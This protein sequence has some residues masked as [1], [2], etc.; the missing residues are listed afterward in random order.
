MA[1]EGPQPNRRLSREE[2]ERKIAD[3]I[4]KRQ[5]GQPQDADDII[6]A[7]PEEDEESEA[8]EVSEEPEKEEEKKPELNRQDIEK[9]TGEQRVQQTPEEQLE[10][11]EVPKYIK[12]SPEAYKQPPGGP[13]VQP[14]KPGVVSEGGGKAVKQGASKAGQAVKSSVQAAGNAIKEAA[15]KAAQQVAKAVA[16]AASKAAAAALS[17]PYVLGAILIIILLI[18]LGIA[19]IALWPNRSLGTTPTQAADILEDHPLIKTVLAMSNSADFQKLLAENK[20]KLTS[21]INSFKNKLNSKYASNSRTGPT[22]AKLDEVL[23]LIAAYTTTDAVKAK[24]IRDKLLEAVKPWSVTL[25]PGGMIFPVSGFS[26]NNPGRGSDYYKYNS[27]RRTHRGIDRGIP[28]GTVF[29][30]P[31][32]SEIVHLDEKSCRDKIDAGWLNK[33]NGGFGNVIIGKV[34]A[35]NQWKGYYWE[36]H[37]LKQYSA[38]A[39]GIKEG[40]IVRQGQIIGLSGHNGKSSKPH[41]HF[42]IDK[43]EAGNQGFPV[44]IGRE[45]QTIDP[46]IPLGWPRK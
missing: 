17:N 40:S 41:I 14:K 18:G 21:E 10:A 6:A 23:K 25:S 27:L 30:A 36:I 39:Y 42:Q 32:D 2:Y 35:D 8:E 22:I 7:E 19:A 20:D 5:V 28:V 46:Y 4:S 16:Q 34:I 44:G 13:A 1:I 31:A 43:P 33:C 3:D 45:E 29:R 9:L 38:G 12:E 11:G 24:E 37:H 15:V 26:A